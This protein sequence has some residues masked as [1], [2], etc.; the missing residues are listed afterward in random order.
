MY[1]TVAMVSHAQRTFVCVDAQLPRATAAVNS[2]DR[3]R[4]RSQTT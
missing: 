1:A 2:K 3:C 4:S